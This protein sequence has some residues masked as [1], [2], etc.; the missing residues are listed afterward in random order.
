MG[1]QILVPIIDILS[2]ADEKKTNIQPTLLYNEGWMLRLVLDWLA[3]NRGIQ[4]KGIDIDKEDKEDKEEIKLSIP[5]DCKWFSEALLPSPFLRGNEGREGYTHADGSVG[6]FCIGCLQ[7]SESVSD[8]NCATGE[9]CP[10]SASAGKNKGKLS[11]KPDCDF[12]YVIE[13]KMG[14]S[15]SAGITNDQ[16]YNQAARSIACIAELLAQQKVTGEEIKNFKHLGF[17]VF[18]PEKHPDLKNISDENKG[19]NKILHKEKIKT[20]IGHRI[21]SLDNESIRWLKENLDYNNKPNSFLNKL[22][23]K[24][25]TWEEILKAIGNSSLNEFYEKCKIYNGIKE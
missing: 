17:Y 3:K 9:F 14:S 16:N 25:I 22:T 10:K 7:N 24:A 1:D 6:K 11:L 12:F 5:D 2:N 4:C 8:N 18:L 23:I 21:G 20:A 15:L 13:A 19:L